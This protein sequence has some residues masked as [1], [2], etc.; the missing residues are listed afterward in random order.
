LTI[1]RNFTGG[2]APASAAGGGNIVDIFNRT[3]DWWEA[4]ILDSHIVDVDFS[5]ANL[6]GNT[7]VV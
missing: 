5:W 2:A 1:N 6:S 4:S 7:L 3:A